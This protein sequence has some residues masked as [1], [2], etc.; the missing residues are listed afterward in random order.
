MK[1]EFDM[2]DS[3]FSR[4]LVDEVKEEK[5]EFQEGYK[6]GFNKGFQEGFKI[7]FQI[8]IQ[9]ERKKAVISFFKALINLDFNY[10][11]AI[12][13][14][15]SFRDIPEEEIKSIISVSSSE[16]NKG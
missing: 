9:I 3:Y 4:F 10:D 2:Q 6:I 16:K 15:A 8:G 12:K 1:Y 13:T 7:G 14:I 11:D 5:N